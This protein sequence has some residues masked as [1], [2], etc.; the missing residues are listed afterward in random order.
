VQRRHSADLRGRV[1]SRD[2]RTFR[3]PGERFTLI[4]L[5]IVAIIGIIAAIT[6]STRAATAGTPLQ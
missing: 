2:Q 6:T 5:L 1:R 4:E 3:H